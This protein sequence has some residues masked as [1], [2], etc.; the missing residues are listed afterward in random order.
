MNKKKKDKTATKINMIN[1]NIIYLK[2]RGNDSR[3]DY[4]FNRKE[5]NNKERGHFAL[6][7][8]KIV[9]NRPAQALRIVTFGKSA[10]LETSGNITCR[11]PIRQ[12]I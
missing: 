7:G 4:Y 9:C 1:D 12:N 3:K 6:K 11:L 10:F 5:C 2:F 8:R